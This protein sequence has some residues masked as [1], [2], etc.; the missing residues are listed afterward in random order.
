M[1][2]IDSPSSIKVIEPESDVG[3]G[4]A[5]GCCVIMLKSS[6]SMNEVFQRVRAVVLGALVIGVEYR[7]K[8]VGLITPDI[9]D[10][11]LE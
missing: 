10:S 4:M 7:L 11:E 3:F 2:D 1:L 8:L 6:S 5:D 9:F